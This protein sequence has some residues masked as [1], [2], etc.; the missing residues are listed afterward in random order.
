MIKDLQVV[1]SAL[2][3]RHPVLVGASMGGAV[4]LAA[5]GDGHVSASA[6]VLVD[7]APRIEPSGSAR[8]QKFMSQNP[9]GF[10]SLDEVAD[11]I[12]AYQTHRQRPRNL[13]GLAKNVRVGVDGK[14]RWHWDPRIR[15]SHSE[16]EILVAELEGCARLITVPTLLIRGG[17]SDILSEDGVAHFLE[18]VPHSDYVNVA[19]AA[20]M[21]AGD[22]NDIFLGAI[23]DFLEREGPMLSPAT[24]PRKKAQ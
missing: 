22:K 21:V 19:N 20:H 6:L 11:A 15:E 17:L 12:A 16:P 2:G 9:D 13:R 7:I 1:I 8:I 10:E 5:V 18:L 24:S 4:S 14:Y 23:A 3:D